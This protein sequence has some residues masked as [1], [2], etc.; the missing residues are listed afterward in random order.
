MKGCEMCEE[1][2]ALAAELAA[3][4]ME[5]GH[6]VDRKLYNE[7]ILTRLKWVV[8]KSENIL[9]KLEGRDAV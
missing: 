8:T 1:L 4:L 5:V 9:G 3:L 7:D 2:S 6:L